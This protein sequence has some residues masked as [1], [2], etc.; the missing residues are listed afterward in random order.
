ME[1]GKRITELREQEGITVNRLANLA[2]ISQSHLRDIELGKKC[3]TVETLTYICDALS[4]SLV[5][6][7]DTQKN[8]I[9]PALLSSVKNLNQKQQKLLSK[10][11]DSI[12]T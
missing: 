6:F 5:A 9:N 8:E 11:L 4:I 2:G 12:M 3:P 10:F 7:F 1:V